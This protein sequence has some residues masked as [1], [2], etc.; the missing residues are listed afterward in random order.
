MFTEGMT[1]GRQSVF[2]MA[3]K[4][5]KP[6]SKEKVHPKGESSTNDFF[7]FP[8]IGWMILVTFG[9]YLLFTSTFSPESALQYIPWPLCDF[10]YYMGKQ[11][12]QIC[13]LLCVSTAVIHS[14]EAAYAGKVCQDKKMTPIA[15]VKWTLMT[16]LFGFASLTRLCAYKPN[17]KQP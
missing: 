7:V 10:V 12:S 3:P 5:N 2:M 11:H 17:I 16:F 1:Q 8:H 15:T 9:L 14:L 13:S 4:Q 6:R